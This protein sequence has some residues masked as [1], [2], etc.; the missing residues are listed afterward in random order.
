LLIAA[1]AFEPTAE[2]LA[3]AGA[4]DLVPAVADGIVEVSRGAVRFAHPLLAQAALASV[5]AP[6]LRALPARLAGASSSDDARARHLGE[7]ADGPDEAAASALAQ[8]AARARGRGGTVDAVALYERASRLSPDATRATARAID[9]AEGAFIDLADLRYADAILKRALEHAEPGPARAEARSLQALVWYFQGRQTEA[10]RLCA[11]ALPEAGADSLTRAKILLRC[12]YLDGQL[13]MERSV[14]EVDEAV[15]ILER[16]PTGADPDLVAQAFLDRANASLQ[17]AVGLREDDIERGRRLHGE[18]GRSWEWDRCDVI[19]FELARHTDDLETALTLLYGQIERRANRGVE[20]PFRFVHASLLNCWRGDWDAGRRWAERAVEAYSREGADLHPAFALRGLA[21]VEAL[22]GRVD[23]ARELASRGLELADE[24]GDLVVAAI[25]RQILGLVALSTGEVEEADR[26]LVAAVEL[27]R[28][29]GARHPLRTRVEGD[30]AEAAIAVGDLERA[31]RAVERIEHAGRATPTPW[32][33]SIGAR[34]R[35]LLE[36]ARGDL[37]AAA[38]ALERAI[39]EH[40]RLPMPF[41]RGR[42]LLARGRVHHR[43]REKKLADAALREA[44]QIFDELGAPLWAAQARTELERVALRRREPSE[45]NETE[46][47]VAELAAQGLSNQ[48]IAQ[49]AF[50]SVKTVEANLTRVYRKLGIR[51]RAALARALV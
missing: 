45:L 27:D 51:S 20:D 29:L 43:R 3:A 34:C 18:S 17:M 26:Q 7:A 31:E 28:R 11:E 24:R 44:L 19:L 12:A 21:L 46:R 50:V 33:L 39:E 4:G 25:H 9:A 42:T 30:H 1:A 2:T 49:R 38:S 23:E 36:A 16:D 14:V 32:V 22:E 41:E 48:E 35:G 40:E 8:A 5:D 6:V 47:R 37:D 10:A 13:D 15:E